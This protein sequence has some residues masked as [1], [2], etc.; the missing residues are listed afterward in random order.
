V[1]GAVRVIGTR[2]RVA[3]VEGECLPRRDRRHALAGVRISV[4][5]KLLDV[6]P[7]VRG[8]RA[9]QRQWVQGACRVA[10]VIVVLVQVPMGQ[11]L[12]LRDVRGLRV[13][14]TDVGPL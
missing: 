7:V 3:V 5:R 4:V 11:D 1:E 14:A 8:R 10:A 13:L 9:P 6:D 2:D 12:R